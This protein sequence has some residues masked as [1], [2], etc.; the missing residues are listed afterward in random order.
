LP[1]ITDIA[2]ALEARRDANFA[3]STIT[4]M[5]VHT[6]SKAARVAMARAA[7]RLGNYTQ[8]AKAVWAAYLTLERAA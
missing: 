6:K 5:I 2:A 4:E 8:E 7:L 1:I 3:R